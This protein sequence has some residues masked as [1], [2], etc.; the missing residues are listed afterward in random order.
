MRTTA[1]EF[2]LS[3]RAVCQALDIELVELEDWNCCG[4]SSAHS[5]D[6]EL[7]LRLPARN[8]ALAQG[9]GLDIVTPCPAC[10]QRT[11][12]ADLQLRADRVWRREMEDLLG[13]TYTGQGRLR[14]VLEV[15]SEPEVI[16]AVRERVT[17]RLTGLRVVSYYGCVLVRPPEITGW[18]DPEHPMRMDRLLE[19]IGAQPVDWSYKVDCCGVSLTL[20]RSDVVV[21][22]STRLAAAAWEAGADVIACACGLCHINLDTRQ[23]LAER[24]PVLYITELIGLAFGLPSVEHWLNKHTVDPWPVLQERGLLA[25]HVLRGRMTGNKSQRSDAVLVVGAAS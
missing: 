19:A 13:F 25:Q 3:T 7:S 14:H 17:R 8:V 21:T 15:L 24:V 6:H 18:D 4:A 16:D 23:A 1:V 2:G 9:A 10:Y 22:L 20:S 5:L 12:V 11:L